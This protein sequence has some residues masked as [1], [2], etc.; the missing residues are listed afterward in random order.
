MK[1][2]DLLRA[3]NKIQVGAVRIYTDNQC[4]FWETHM[5]KDDFIILLGEHQNQW[6]QNVLSVLFPW[7]IRWVYRLDVEVVE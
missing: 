3:R 7:G 2:G 6:G 1:R 5:R 4:E